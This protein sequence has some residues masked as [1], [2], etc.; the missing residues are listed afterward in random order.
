MYVLVAVS[1]FLFLPH[2]AFAMKVTVSP[3]SVTLPEN[4][5]SQV[6]TILLDEPIIAE[7]GDAFATISITSS[8]DRA[9]ASPQVINYDATDWFHSKTF[10]V[11]TVGDFIHNTENRVT[12]RLSTYSNSEYYNGYQ[13]SAVITL[14]DDDSA[15]GTVL[16]FGCKIPTATNYNPNGGILA[17]DTTCV[18]A[19]VGDCAPGAAFSSVTGARCANN[20][21]STAAKFTFQKNLKKGMDDGDVLQ[22]QKFLNTHGSPIA[23]SGNASPGNEVTTFGA[24]TVVALAQYQ[25]AHGI[26]PATGYFGPTTRAYVNAIIEKEN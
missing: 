26:L 22:L 23:A 8:D 25:K 12:L 2:A 3:S 11:T 6:Y 17:D 9:V 24:K 5:G 16:L 7:S 21:P 4:G 13:T 10:T 19:K 15:G 14:V 20:S 18:F 1:A